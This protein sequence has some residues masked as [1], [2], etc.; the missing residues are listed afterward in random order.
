[1]ITRLG[2]PAATMVRD[3][4]GAVIIMATGIGDR[5]RCSTIIIMV[6]SWDDTQLK[7][8]AKGTIVGVKNVYGRIRTIT[9][10]R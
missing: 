2:C 1:M 8:V 6:L 7:C 10:W 4:K 3:S 9:T 5:L